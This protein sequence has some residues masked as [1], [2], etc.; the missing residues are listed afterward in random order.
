M[1]RN[2]GTTESWGTVQMKV[3][4]DMVQSFQKKSKRLIEDIGAVWLQLNAIQ[5][6]LK[7]THNPLDYQSEKQKWD[8]QKS[9]DEHFE[10]AEEQGWINTDEA[11]QGALGV[12]KATGE[13]SSGNSNNSNNNDNNDNKKK[14][15][16]K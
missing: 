16:D 4:T 3:I 13:K 5:G 2:S 1:N 6:T 10:K 8:A 15:K 7:V 9:K 12:E 14:K 11:A